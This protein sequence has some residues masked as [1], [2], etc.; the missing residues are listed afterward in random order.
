MESVMYFID[1]N[2]HNLQSSVSVDICNVSMN[3]QQSM[4]TGLDLNV[5]VPH[6]LLC[7]AVHYFFERLCFVII[8][9]CHCSGRCLLYSEFNWP[10]TFQRGGIREGWLYTLDL[11]KLY[12][13]VILRDSEIS[14]C[15]YYWET[16]C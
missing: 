6:I 14:T 3:L 15:I 2:L 9:I 13:K 4:T 10:V 1:I 7:Y 8:A 11:F 16:Q 5:F 12:S